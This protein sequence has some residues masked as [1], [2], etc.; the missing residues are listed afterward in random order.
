[1]ND[2]LKGLSSWKGLL[3]KC[4][5][6]GIVCLWTINLWTCNWVLLSLLCAVGPAL[7]CRP[8]SYIC[9]P[10]A[11]GANWA[12]QGCWGCLVGCHQHGCCQHSYC[13]G[14]VKVRW[15]SPESL[16]LWCLWVPGKFLLWW[17]S[18]KIRYQEGHCKVEEQKWSQA[19]AAAWWQQWADQK[20]ALSAPCYGSRGWQSW[21][22]AGLGFL[23]MLEW[24]VPRKCHC[25]H[26]YFQI[27]S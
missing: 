14:L 21:S 10:R 12:V 5:I 18:C 6:S 11:A 3:F 22:S 16:Q 4:L 15:G 24:W 19:L 26:A 13:K 17:A 9:P 2:W 20:P 25:L 23:M 1:M 8:I 27:H 7:V